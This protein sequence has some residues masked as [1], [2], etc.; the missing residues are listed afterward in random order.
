MVKQMKNIV[1]IILGFTLLLS[2]FYWFQYRPTR[3]RS[4]CHLKAS[5]DNIS[6]ASRLYEP[7]YNACL[8]EKGLK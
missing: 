7:R 6:A 2:W 1:L 5:E 4:F 8:H 3:I